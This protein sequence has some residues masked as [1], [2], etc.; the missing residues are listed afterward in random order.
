MEPSTPTIETA[1]TKSTTVIL[2]DMWVKLR[3]LSRLHVV[4]CFLYSCRL[5]NSHKHDSMHCTASQ[6]HKNKI[7]F[8]LKFQSLTFM[9]NLL[10][11]PQNL[12]KNAFCNSEQFPFTMKICGKETSAKRFFCVVLQVYWSS[13]YAYSLTTIIAHLFSKLCNIICEKK[14][15]HLDLT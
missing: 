2:P 10:W 6:T 15:L 14:L 4:I 5:L 13:H 1:E 12:K 8:F 7:P 9:H 3:S 11:K